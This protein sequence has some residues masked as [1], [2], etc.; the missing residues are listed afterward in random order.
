M[1]LTQP[2][3]TYMHSCTM[4]VH[5]IIDISKYKYIFTS[6]SEIAIIGPIEALH[7]TAEFGILPVV[8][9]IVIIEQLEHDL[10][11]LAF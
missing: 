11:R 5:T 2:L 3:S 6:M 1:S 4:Y 10:G 8:P 7:A 9:K